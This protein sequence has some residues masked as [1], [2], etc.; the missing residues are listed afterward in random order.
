MRL[1]ERRSSRDGVRAPELV[2]GQPVL[3]SVRPGHAKHPC[4]FFQF[5]AF[6]CSMCMGL[7]YDIKLTPENAEWWRQERRRKEQE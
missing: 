6:L 1:I 4:P 3:R 7:G 2:E 5:P